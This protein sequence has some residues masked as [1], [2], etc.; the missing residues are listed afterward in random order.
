VYRQ[1]LRKKK[2]SEGTTRQ[3]IQP[4]KGG[5]RHVFVIISKGGVMLLQRGF[6]VLP[7]TRFLKLVPNL[8]GGELA[9]GER[10]Q[11]PNP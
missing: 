6:N 7:K 1:V 8:K 3:S 2:D 4:K 10:M 11:Q 9:R 5:T